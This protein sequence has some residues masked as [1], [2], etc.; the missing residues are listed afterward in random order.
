LKPGILPECEEIEKW[1]VIRSKLIEEI[2]VMLIQCQ[3]SK[4]A[5]SD[6]PK[7]NQVQIKLKIQMFEQ[8]I[9][10]IKAFDIHLAF[11]L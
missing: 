4:P 7:V 10:D 11:E 9:S 8:E 2:G 3:V 5:Q 1:V 6:E